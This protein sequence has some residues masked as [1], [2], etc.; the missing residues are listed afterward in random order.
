MMKTMSIRRCEAMQGE[1]AAPRT[2]TPRNSAPRTAPG[3]QR[4]RRRKC[5]HSRRKCHRLPG[6][7]PRGNGGGDGDED[8]CDHDVMMMRMAIIGKQKTTM[9]QMATTK[10]GDDDEEDGPPPLLSPASVRSGACACGGGHSGSTISSSPRMPSS[11]SETVSSC[12]VVHTS[13][14]YLRD[15]SYTSRI[16]PDPYRDPS[17]NP[18]S[19]L[20]RAYQK[21][22][23]TTA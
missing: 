22:N 15:R 17:R 9:M 10:D 2:R 16:R 11:D 23:T 12:V 19:R 3:T 8:G 4:S 5:T 18:S 14:W 13:P 21:P 20:T 6:T 1:A 7:W